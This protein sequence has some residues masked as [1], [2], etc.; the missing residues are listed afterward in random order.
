MLDEAVKVRK[1]FSNEIQRLYISLS[2]VFHRLLCYISTALGQYT[3]AMDRGG[4]EMMKTRSCPGTKDKRFCA[5]CVC[6]NCP[7]GIASMQC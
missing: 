7:T 6:S 1:I 5:P 3:G 2:T 4:G